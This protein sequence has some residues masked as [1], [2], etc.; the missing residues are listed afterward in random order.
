MLKYKCGNLITILLI[1][2]IILNFLLYFRIKNNSITKVD[3]DDADL[4]NLDELKT[5]NDV[6]YKL[7][8]EYNILKSHKKLYNE[9]VSKSSTISTYNST[10]QNKIIDNNQIV[11]SKSGNKKVMIFTMDSIYSYEQN[12]LNGGASGIF[13]FILCYNQL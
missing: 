7:Q 1:L 4:I 6:L 13:F 9:N 3:K 11:T 10:Q 8:K 2:I 5:L 12:S